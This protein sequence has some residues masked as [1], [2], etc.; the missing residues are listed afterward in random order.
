MINVRKLLHRDK[1]EVRQLEVG[2]RGSWHS[3]VVVGVL[4][5]CRDIRYNELLC[6]SG[7]SKLVESIPVT[8][9]IE[10]LYQRPYVKSNYRGR[11]RPIPPR[12]E[13]SSVNVGLK[14]GV[15]VD[16][17]FKEAWWEGV[18]V[19]C[20]EGAK[21]RR[22]YFPD[23]GD[24]RMY[25]L[26]DLRVTLQWDELS[27]SWRERGTWLLVNLVRE[28]NKDGDLFQLIKRV[29]SRLK[30][31]YGYQKMIS[32]WTCGAY[33]V[34]KEYF[35]EV[36]CDATVTA[37][38]KTL[39][40]PTGSRRHVTK[41]RGRKSRRGS[42]L[43][44][45]VLTRSMRRRKD[46]E[47]SLAVRTR[48][49]CM[50]EPDNSPISGATNGSHLVDSRCRQSHSTVADSCIIPDSPEADAR[51]EYDQVASVCCA[52]IRDCATEK[53]EFRHGRTA[54]NRSLPTTSPCCYTS[55][56]KMP[57]KTPFR[58][59]WHFDDN[60][61]IAKKV[62]PSKTISRQLKKRTR[63]SKM[64]RQVDN[65]VSIKVFDY[66]SVD[67]RKGLMQTQNE[68][69]FTV[70]YSVF[71]QGGRRII[72]RRCIKKRSPLRIKKTSSRKIE[73]DNDN[74]NSTLS[75]NL[76]GSKSPQKED[77]VL[78]SQ[79]ESTLPATDSCQELGS[80]DALNVPDKQR[81]RRRRCFDSVCFICQYG[82]EL[83][84]CD[85]C[86]SSYHIP[87][88][89]P[90]AAVIGE[91][92]CPSCRCGLCGLKDC[93]SDDQS[94]SD[95]CYQCCRQYHLACLDQS[96]VSVSEDSRFCS[97][98]C[99]EICAR[100]HQ[101]LRA[102][103]PTSV[104]GLTWSIT[105]SRRNDCNVYNERV[106]PLIQVSQVL[107]VFHECF[108]PI[109]EPL[110][111]RDLVAD[112]VY[113]SGSKL[114][115]LDFHGFY[116]MAVVNADEVVCAATIRIHGQKVAEMPLIAT[117]FKYRRQGM[118][119]LLLHELQKM[120]AEL[121]VERLVLPGIASLNETWVSSFGFT[122]MPASDRRELSGY[123]FVVFQG[124]TLFQKILLSSED[125]AEPCTPESIKANDC[126]PSSSDICDVQP[127]EWTGRVLRPITQTYFRRH[128]LNRDLR[129]LESGVDYKGS[130]QES[131]KPDRAQPE[132]SQENWTK[133]EHRRF[134]LCYK[135]RRKLEAVN[136]G[137]TVMDGSDKK[138]PI[139]KYVYK[140][141]R[142]QASRD[143]SDCF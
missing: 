87:C 127:I 15:C 50:S 54:Q 57:V 51:G 83:L 34:W 21:E 81:A 18:I 78:G 68:V 131:M 36:I 129:N 16:V 39:V 62:K 132:C 14:F 74:L 44:V 93:A 121:G 37:R 97:K 4:D 63:D 38:P 31:H 114:R 3:G 126:T 137:K 94:F 84:H 9:A 32:E 101:L 116:V 45:S 59:K 130:S 99:F 35:R 105:R 43:N 70:R 107:N 90:E 113:N 49:M 53:G 47:V 27:G 142:I 106:H 95:V 25:K 23:E 11:I 77:N 12:S 22:V 42:Y 118:C 88:V 91:L 133:N 119:R 139:L 19:D 104:E 111:G 125:N 109:T 85:V 1:V 102:S 117:P 56:S 123:P 8:G 96:G 60:S 82:D 65:H 100:L 89:D 30:V 124:T 71:R 134:S 86:M 98:N 141:R 128:R 138:Q 33:C 103:N 40:F 26:S 72:S 75:E 108:K 6:E 17:L 122:E 112:I 69:G 29:W 2:L 7:N 46:K 110:S 135:R 136:D 55:D 73:E 24:E 120:L 58:R 41:K 143:P 28:H 52:H 92:S 64:T 5:S 48:R 76:E 13:S 20:D 140:R 79:C 61:L 66:K 10:G 80:E 67:R 115:R